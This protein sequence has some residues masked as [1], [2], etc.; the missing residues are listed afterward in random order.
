MVDKIWDLEYVGTCCAQ[1]CYRRLPHVCM[2]LHDSEIRMKTPS[3]ASGVKR[4]NNG[5]EDSEQEPNKKWKEDRARNKETRKKLK[6]KQGRGP[7]R[8]KQRSQGNSSAARTNTIN[9]PVAYRRSTRG[10]NQAKGYLGKLKARRLILKKSCQIKEVRRL[11]KKGV[12]KG[13]EEKYRKK[14]NKSKSTCIKKLKYQASTSKNSR[15][16]LRLLKR[17][18][19]YGKN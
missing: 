8:R 6:K 14:A 12:L 1:Q 9:W 7:T 5:D 16:K 17:Q 18:L 19:F 15:E 10:H 13:E 3:N 4:N 11:E 2:W